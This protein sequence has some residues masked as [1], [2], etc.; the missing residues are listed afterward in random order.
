[1]GG[2]IA[3]TDKDEDEQRAMPRESF[4]PL[5]RRDHRDTALWQVVVEASP[6]REMIVDRGTCSEIQ[7]LGWDTTHSVARG[8]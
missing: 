8:S 2:Q 6:E 1:M 7:S 4:R 5:E 3:S